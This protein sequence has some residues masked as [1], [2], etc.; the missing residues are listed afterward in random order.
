MPG[1]IPHRRNSDE[2]DED[3]EEL[4][5]GSVSPSSQMSSSSKRPRLDQEEISEVRFNLLCGHALVVMFLLLFSTS[6][7]LN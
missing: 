6:D 2:M 7:N 3:E 4:V 5:D 1:L